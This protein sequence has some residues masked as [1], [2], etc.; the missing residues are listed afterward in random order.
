MSLIL[1]L[2][3]CCDLR[4]FCSM[5]MDTNVVRLCPLIHTG[6]ARSSKR[7][8]STRAAA[9]ATG[10]IA[11]F[12]SIA[13][14]YVFF[15]TKREIIAPSLPNHNLDQNAFEPKHG[16]FFC[17][18]IV[19]RTFTRLACV[20]PRDALPKVQILV[21]ERQPFQGYGRLAVAVLSVAN[22]IPTIL[23]VRGSLIWSY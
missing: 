18:P 8:R 4:Y 15:S 9:N 22:N 7:C 1:S 19:E 10:C 2:E 6:H 17:G 13:L 5:N 3:P 14:I 16:V 21:I 12:R 11:D 23:L 20:Y